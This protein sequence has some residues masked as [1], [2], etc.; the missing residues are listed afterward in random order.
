M[1]LCISVFF[2]M[3]GM[4]E[5]EEIRRLTL[6]DHAVFTVILLV[7]VISLVIAL[8]SLEHLRW[9]SRNGENAT[10]SP[11]TL[12]EKVLRRRGILLLIASFLAALAF[13]IGGKN[14]EKELAEASD[15]VR[16]FY[17]V[18][19]ILPLVSLTS[20][21]LL[22]KLALRRLKKVCKPEWIR[23]EGRCRA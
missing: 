18:C 7:S 2:T 13:F 8:R 6:G 19:C 21:F 10:P 23:R 9:I 12:Q 20:S 22:N 15:A 16:V 4:K 1:I 5:G 3:A 11:L 17:I 14:S